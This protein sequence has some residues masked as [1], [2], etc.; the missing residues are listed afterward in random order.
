MGADDVS[1]RKAGPS[2]GEPYPPFATGAVAGGTTKYDHDL[3]HN[4]RFAFV[5]SSSYLSGAR[6]HRLDPAGAVIKLVIQV[7]CGVDER[8]VAEGLRKVAQLLA[9]GPNLL[10]NR[11]RWFA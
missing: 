11:P 5:T 10:R 9:G 1:L 7:H 3:P 8:K 6:E 2:S 4:L